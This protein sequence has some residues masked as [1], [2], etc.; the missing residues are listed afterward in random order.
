MT[1]AMHCDA[2]DCYNWQREGRKADTFVAIV[3]AG[4][5][6]AIAHACCLDC[7]MHWAAKHSSPT[8]KLEP[9]I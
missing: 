5:D 1:W 3:P 7:L 8:I 9:P 4:S 2:D 6:E